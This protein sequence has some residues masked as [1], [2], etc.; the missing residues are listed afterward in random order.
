MHVRFDSKRRIAGN[1]ATSGW[2]AGCTA[3]QAV[4]S[5]ESAQVVKHF[6][7]RLFEQTFSSILSRTTRAGYEASFPLLDG[8]LLSSKLWL[9]QHSDCHLALSAL[10]VCVCRD[11][12]GSRD[13]SDSHHVLLSTKLRRLYD[14]ASLAKLSEKVEVAE[15][16]LVSVGLQRTAIA[17]M[18]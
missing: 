17:S 6:D 8:F 2:L 16:H 7:S 10:C 9:K 4:T 15:S 11:A 3:H 18:R 5:H 13:A 14:L 12:V 1:C